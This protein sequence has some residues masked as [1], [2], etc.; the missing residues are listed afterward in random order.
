MIERCDY[1]CLFEEG[2]ALSILWEPVR[3]FSR[4]ALDFSREK[5]GSSQDELGFSWEKM[6]H[7]VI[8]FVDGESFV[9]A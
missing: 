8:V 2:K 5:P 4:A 3:G 9:D 7:P 1:T 6:V